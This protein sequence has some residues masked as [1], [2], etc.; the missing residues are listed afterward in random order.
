MA[1]FDQEELFCEEEIRD[2]SLHESAHS[3]IGE[4]S[5]ET[6]VWH[7]TLD[8]NATLQYQGSV[9]DINWINIGSPIVANSGENSYE[10]VTDFFPEYRM[11]A[12]CSTA[13]TI[14]NICVFLLKAGVR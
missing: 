7:S 6:I 11:T 12:V 3:Y 2:T 14:G 1:N 9:D 4:Y 13:P 10:T 5:A 8:Q